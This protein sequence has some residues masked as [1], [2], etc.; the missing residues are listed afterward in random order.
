VKEGPMLIA[1]F[2]GWNVIGGSDFNHVTVD[3]NPPPVNAMVTVS[4][5]GWGSVGFGDDAIKEVAAGIVEFSVRN[6]QDQD[7][8]TKFA[9]LGDI[10]HIGFGSLP[11]GIAKNK[12][13]HVTML[14]MTWDCWTSGLMTVLGTDY[15]ESSNP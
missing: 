4:I 6:D 14:I 5:G 13:S 12:L 1:N 3:I 2:F 8:T 9:D 15:G 11:I 10:E 7:V